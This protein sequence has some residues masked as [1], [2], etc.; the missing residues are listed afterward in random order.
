MV[1][2]ISS[3]SYFVRGV[4]Y[5]YVYDSTKGFTLQSMYSIIESN[6]RGYAVT[7]NCVNPHLSEIKYWTTSFDLFP[8]ILY[9]LT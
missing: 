1:F 8:E 2:L 4:L 3:A 5:G 9:N 7:A 6:K